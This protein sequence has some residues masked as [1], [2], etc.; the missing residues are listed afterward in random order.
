MDAKQEIWKFAK[1]FPNHEVSDLGNVRHDGKALIPAQSG[2]G[3]V[4][5]LLR[6]DGK[7]MT[8]QVHRL[9]AE[10]FLPPPPNNAL[11]IDHL[12]MNRSNNAS[13]NLRWVSR[14]KN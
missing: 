11:G 8:V 4:Q 14:H 7:R 3:H 5:V 10:A 1:G 6:H 9:V 2:D 12:D 13:P